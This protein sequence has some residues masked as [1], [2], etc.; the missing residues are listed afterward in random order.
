MFSFTSNNLPFYRAV[1]ISK[2][3]RSLLGLHYCNRSENES[4]YPSRQSR[5]TI[6]L[7]EHVE[8]S[9]DV[10]ERLYDNSH[11]LN[12]SSQ[13]PEAARVVLDLKPRDHIGSS[14]RQ[15]HWLPIAKRVT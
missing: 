1:I 2:P 4:C 12:T 5:Q 10:D 8:D 11:M 6:F 13:L 9:V 15:L 7:V 3:R 14:L